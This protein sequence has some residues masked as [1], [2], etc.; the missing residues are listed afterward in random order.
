MGSRTTARGSAS[1][2]ALPLSRAKSVHQ[3]VA[4]QAH[5]PGLLPVAVEHGR[6]LAGPPHPARGALAELGAWLGD[7]ADLGH[8]GAHSLLTGDG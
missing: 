5:V 3:V 2:V 7:D 1:S 6:H 8:G 4:G